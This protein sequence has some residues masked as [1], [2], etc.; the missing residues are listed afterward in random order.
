MGSRIQTWPLVP[1]T[2]PNSSPQGRGSPP[3]PVE[4]VA[5]QFPELEILELIGAGVHFCATCDGPFY[6]GEHVAVVGGGRVIGEVAGGV[7][8]V[9]RP[10]DLREADVV[11]ALQ[12]EAVLHDLEIPH[13][14]RI[15]LV[16]KYFPP[17]PRISGV[18][19]YL[20]FL[21]V[22]LSMRCT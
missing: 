10:E 15:V 13:G 6:K 17:Y 9:A 11:A 20:A 7:G 12:A 1:G 14:R 21:M 18:L 3:P 4:E 16:V 2:I 22:W 8:K 19:T 5:A